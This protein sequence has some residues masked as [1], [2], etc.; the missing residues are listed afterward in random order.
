LPVLAQAPFAGALMVS[1]FP[2]ALLLIFHEH[3]LWRRLFYLCASLSLGFNIVFY[4]DRGSW[5]ACVGSMVVLAV[6]TQRKKSSWAVSAVAF[7]CV[8]WGLVAMGPHVEG[9]RWVFSGR[10]DSATLFQS[11]RFTIW[12]KV[13]EALPHLPVFGVGWGET[14]W[15]SLVAR[16]SPLSYPNIYGFGPFFWTQPHNSYLQLLLSTGFPTFVCFAALIVLTMWV[17]LKS[18][19]AEE[20]PP[21]RE[22]L[23]GMFAGLVG[24]LTQSALDRTLWLVPMNVLLWMLVGAVWALSCPVGGLGRGTELGDSPSSSELVTRSA[25]T[26]GGRPDARG[27]PV[28][29]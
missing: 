4:L 11:V 13:L 27:R 21:R 26:H 8:V 17:A 14:P 18:L 1:F 28:S 5:L 7:G 10:A 20:P 9:L 22:V 15:N 2:L 12:G 23:L 16:Y 3:G 19:G 24:L 6:L 29:T 25:I